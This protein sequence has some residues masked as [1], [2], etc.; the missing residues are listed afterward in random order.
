MKR[1]IVSMLAAGM[2]LCSCSPQ[3]TEPSGTNANTAGA[4]L[5]PGAENGTENGSVDPY[6]N[7]AGINLLVAVDEF[8]RTVP[9]SGANKKDR[10]V[11]IMY[12]LWHGSYANR[13][14]D[15]TKIIEEKGLDY[16]LYNLKDY[17]PTGIPQYWGEPLYGYY[18]SDDEYIIRK[19]MILLM[20]AG[21]DFIAFDASNTI[22]YPNEVRKICEVICEL[23]GEGFNVP[24]ITY[25]THTASIQTVL[26]AYDEIYSHEEYREAWYLIDGKPL[27]IAQTDPEKDKERTTS[28]HAHLSAYDPEPLPEE[29]MNFFYFRTPA[30][31]GVDPVTEDGWPWVDW[32]FPNALYGNLMTL[33]PASHN[34]SM[35]SW[36]AMQ[37]DY[38]EE[39]IPK[40][41]WSGNKVSWGRG[42]SVNDMR[43]N[44]S[45]AAKG[46]FF[47]AQWDIAKENEPEIV[48]LDGWNEW[49]CGYAQNA[50]YGNVAEA[51]D[52]FNMEFSRDI[53]L[54][55][56][57]YND[58]FL[59]QTAMNAK[60]YKCELPKTFVK[61]AHKTIDINAGIGQ[62]EEIRALYRCT[63]SANFG[64]DSKGIERKL[65]YTVPAAANS[66]QDVKVAC[67]ETNIYF[68]IRSDG[69]IKIESAN[70]M[71][72]FIGTGTPEK[73]GWEG[74]EYVLNR[75]INGGK[76]A[77]GRLHEDFSTDNAGSAD[78]SIN[79]K[80]MQICIPRALIG[81]D[82]GSDNLYFKVADSVEHPED[83]MDY[84]VTGR[85]MPMGRFSYQYLG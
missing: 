74:Y 15:T 57:G 59:I 85:C 60:E 19:H 58:A 22:T 18:R 45:R 12:W 9:V 39:K 83:I 68:M 11:G 41:A 27:M 73:K 43:N 47:Q 8:G 25:Y 51:Y 75:E 49:C 34:Y 40:A 10:A 24:Q 32:S 6:D 71:N 23:R 30:W 42:Y 81:M 69:D 76:T 70:S 64:R 67:D 56:G 78:I 7:P 2:L 62:W 61:D 66:I 80:I 46:T 4:S 28:Q 79:G 77:I 82:K 54:M 21:V 16:A 53:E 63:G 13:A 72:L 31:C 37:Y 3:Q 26:Q 20:Y 33:S 52:S 55:K 29:I 17:N 65:Q 38:P 1:F 5:S 44:T 14:V 36:A 50:E 84:Y 35:M 48:Y